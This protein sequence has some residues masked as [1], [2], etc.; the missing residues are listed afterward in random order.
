MGYDTP[1]LSEADARLLTRQI[2]RHL[3][4]LGANPVRFGVSLK[5]EGFSFTADL[6]GRQVTVQTG[7]GNVRYEAVAKELLIRALDPAGDWG[8]RIYRIEA[9]DRPASSL[10][11]P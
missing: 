9:P 7:Q 11:L 10:L 2:V 3:R 5:A 4:A 6:H 8:D 1:P